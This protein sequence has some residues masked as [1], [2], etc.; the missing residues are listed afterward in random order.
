MTTNPYASLYRKYPH[1]CKF[2]GTIP[3]SNQVQYAKVPFW[4]NRQ[5]PLSKHFWGLYIISI[6]NTKGRV[7]LDAHNKDWLNELDCQRNP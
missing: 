4:N 2:L 5:I 3:S 7:F 6:W 1:I